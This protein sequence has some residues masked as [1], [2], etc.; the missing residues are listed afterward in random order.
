MYWPWPDEAQA[1]RQL[2]NAETNDIWNK[3]KSPLAMPREPKM[4]V[5]DTKEVLSDELADGKPQGLEDV[6]TDD[7]ADGNPRDVTEVPSD[8]LAD[9]KPRV[10]D[11]R[12]LFSVYTYRLITR[13][14]TQAQIVFEKSTE[15]SLVN[16]NYEKL[17]DVQ[18]MWPMVNSTSEILLNVLTIFRESTLRSS[19]ALNVS[20]FKTH[21][22]SPSICMEQSPP[23]EASLLARR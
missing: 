23:L 15:A 16:K 5:E 8:E 10:V 14:L 1:H 18:K 2:F 4:A 21:P 19:V 20:V 6:S 3:D 12:G 13:Q 22:L 11:P 9:E 7:L 17:R